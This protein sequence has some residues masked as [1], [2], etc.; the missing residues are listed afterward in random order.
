MHPD[1]HGA[2]FPFDL[3][4]ATKLTD[5]EFQ[6]YTYTPTVQWITATLRTAKCPNLRRIRISSS[7]AFDPTEERTQEEWRELD[8]LLVRLWTSHSIRP[9]ID[10]PNRRGG[11]DL[12]GVAP[13]FLPELMAV[14]A[15][16]SIVS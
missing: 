6:L 14:G 10:L 16:D 15:L 7:M 3:S 2:P 12:G 13:G 8:C 5:L 1:A 11:G 4:K 9:E